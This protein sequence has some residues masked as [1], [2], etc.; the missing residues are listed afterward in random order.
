MI[1]PTC[2]LAN[3]SA[4][5]PFATTDLGGCT[6]IFDKRSSVGASGSSAFFLQYRL[7]GKFIS[8]FVISQES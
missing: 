2:R 3:E 6:G 4:D 5:P 7:K 8:A 1:Q